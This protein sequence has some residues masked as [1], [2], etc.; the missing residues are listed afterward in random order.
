MTPKAVLRTLDTV[1]SMLEPV[2]LPMAVVGGLA[3]SAW[4]H[5]RA[6]QDVDL[7]IGIGN[8]NSDE[9]L[10]RLLPAGFRPKR[11]PPVIPLKNSEVLQLLYEP[12]NVFVDLQIDLLL[13]DTEYHREALTRR[14]PLTLPDVR[15]EVYVLSCEDLIL[16]KLIAGRMID[17]ADVSALLRANRT[18]LDQDYLQRWVISLELTRDYADV[19]RETFPD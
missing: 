3:L 13:A 19:F 4:K 8:S 16:H 5:V 1:W 9:L 18:E 6:T 15:R 12:P 2:G 11:D 7:L 17:R 14:I 10:Q